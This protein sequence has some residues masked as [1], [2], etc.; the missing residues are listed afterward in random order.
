MDKG[1]VALP[2][3]RNASIKLHFKKVKQSCVVKFK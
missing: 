1:D 2:Q 3:Q